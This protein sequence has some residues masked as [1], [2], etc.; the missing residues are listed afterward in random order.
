[1]PELYVVN[2]YII[3]NNTLNPVKYFDSTYFKW[4]WKICLSQG[5]R[6]IG[7]REYTDCFVV[8]LK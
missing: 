6:D 7:K 5:K 3:R 4:F 1:M 8:V 2:S